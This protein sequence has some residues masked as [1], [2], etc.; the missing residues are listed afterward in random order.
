MSGPVKSAEP[1]Y[2][3]PTTHWSAI[4]AT[5]SAVP[6]DT[7]AA[8][9][10]LCARYWYPL[11]GFVRRQGHAHHAAEDLTQGFLAR[12]LANDGLAKAHPARGRFRSFLLAALR[13]FLINDWHRN[14]AGKRGGGESA[15]PVESQAAEENFAREAVDPGLNP[16]QAFERNWALCVI[17][18]ALVMLRAEYAANGREALFDAIAPGIWGGGAP[19]PQAQQA[20]RLGLSVTAL[21][22]TV[23]R[24]R[25]R[26]RE[27]LEL[28]I[29]AT[30]E[31]DG[32][33]AAELN[34]LIAAVGKPRSP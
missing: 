8:L 5:G 4:L 15:Q 33:V 25:K 1:R 17:D 31:T 27:H 16:E 34:Y 22:V 6:A 9:E 2:S 20:E 24:M 30:V 3:F 23:H 19:E 10:N 18:Q 21:K 13:N 11:Y 12:L 29:R 26:L 7:R 32:E 28:Q 14:Q